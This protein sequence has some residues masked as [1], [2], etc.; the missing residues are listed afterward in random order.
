LKGRPAGLGAGSSLALDETLPI[1]KQIAEALEYAHERGVIHRDLKPANVKI[2]QEGTVKVLDFG[3][4]KVLDTQDS[5]ATMDMA[6]SPTLSAMATQ[7][8]MILGTAAYMSPEQAKGQRVDRLADI[9]AFGCVLFEMLTGRKSF[10]GETVSDVLAA[11]IMKDPDWTAL[12][13]TT[14]PSIQKLVRRCLQ[15]DQRQ[16]LR[17]IGEARIAIEETLSGTGVSPVEVHG[18][19]AHATPQRRTLPWVIAGILASALISGFV[20]WK[21]TPRAPQSP[22]HFSAITNFAGVQADPAIS[23]D[24]SSVAFVSNRDGHFNIY[25]GLVGGGNLVKITHDP[26]L[27][28]SP[29]W[30]PNGTTLAYAR[31][32]HAG[33]WDIWEI[34]ALGGTP[35]RVILNSAYPA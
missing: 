17:D 1:A 20:V 33:I 12:P 31:L 22:M 27:E 9:W 18:Q 14:P 24:G 15:K 23:P 21:L 26:N 11:V 3:L 35:R 32:N 4:A 28:S 13:D 2:T 34:P 29:S 19:D 8:G 10:D 25:V 7:A 16:R 6:N 30:S 5:T